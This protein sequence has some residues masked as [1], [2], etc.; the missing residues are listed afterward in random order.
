MAPVVPVERDT[1]TM[2]EEGLAVAHDGTWHVVVPMALL[3]AWETLV[4]EAGMTGREGALQ[5]QGVWESVHGLQGKVPVYVTLAPAETS[6]DAD[7]TAFTVPVHLQPVWKLLQD[8]VTDAAKLLATQ[9]K[10]GPCR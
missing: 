5:V 2:R 9:P 1:V 4:R 3:E 8:G 7:R 6:I 10:P